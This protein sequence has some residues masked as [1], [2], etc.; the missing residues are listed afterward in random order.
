MRF[1]RKLGASAAMAV[2][3]LAIGAA[4]ASA[5]STAPLPSTS[6]ANW[7]GVD[8]TC[9][10]QGGPP[11]AFTAHSTNSV[12]HNISPSADIANCDVVL[13]GVLN[14]DG[15]SAITSGNVTGPGACPAIHVDF[16]NYPSWP[17]QACE[18]TGSS[19]HQMWDRLEAHFTAPGLTVNGELFLHLQTAAGADGDPLALGRALASAPGPLY[20]QV[21][22]SNDAIVANPAVNALSAPY[23]FTTPGFTNDIT[24]TS[25]ADVACGWP[26]LT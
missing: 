10:N 1:T 11:C 15:S 2:A 3:V 22:T 9:P 25:N 19:P 14:A 5:A 24:L 16:T 7:T 4:S 20:A 26:E 6:S 13:N 17:D 12:L 18:Y 23:A 8:V 21:G